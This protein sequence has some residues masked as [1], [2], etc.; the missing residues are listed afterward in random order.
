MLY[1]V[2]LA[3]GGIKITTLVVIHIDWIGRCKSNYNILRWL[4]ESL[5]LNTKWAIVQLYH[6]N[7][8][9]FDDNDVW[10]VLDQNAYR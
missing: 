6:E 2:H 1:Q 7:K 5:L 3:M 9:H 4:S 8:S 10:F